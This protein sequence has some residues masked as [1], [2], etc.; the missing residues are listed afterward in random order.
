MIVLKLDC[1]R[2]HDMTP[3]RMP[4][5]IVTVMHIPNRSVNPGSYPFQTN[6]TVDK[7][8]V[9]GDGAAAWAMTPNIDRS[10]AT[11]R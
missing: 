5:S 6:E 8:V 4:D 11:L 1:V 10:P 3:S 2:A 7:I 9:L